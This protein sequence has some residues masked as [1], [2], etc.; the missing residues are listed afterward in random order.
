MVAVGSAVALT[1]GSLLGVGS[2]STIERVAG[3][4][5][6][7]PGAASLLVDAMAGTGSGS[8][9]QEATEQATKKRTASMKNNRN[10]G[11]LGLGRDKDRSFNN[12]RPDAD[13]RDNLWNHFHAFA[14]I[15]L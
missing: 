9:V 13:R 4:A 6:T 12:L 10:A 7:V 15:Q 5:G 11:T 3:E 14:R 8:C 1:V 2:A